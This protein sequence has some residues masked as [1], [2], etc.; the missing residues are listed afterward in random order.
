MTDVTKLTAD[1]ADLKI[2]VDAADAEL[3]NLAAQVAAL[4]VGTVTQAQIDA[5]DASV[6]ALKANLDTTVTKD[7]P[8]APA[9]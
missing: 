1:L 9:A 8:A 7:T 5:L 6:V 3:D 4:Q 2:S